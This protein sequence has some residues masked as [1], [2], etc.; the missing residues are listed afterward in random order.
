MSTAVTP[1]QAIE[2]NGTLA[3]PDAWDVHT[4]IVALRNLIVATFLQL[5]EALCRFKELRGWAK[6]GYPTFE[7]YLADPDVDISRSRAYKLMAVH[8]L[9]VEMFACASDTLLA[10]GYNKLGLLVPH[11]HSQNVDE[12][13][14]KAA[15][16]SRSDLR[17]ELRE[18][19][20]DDATPPLP[21]DY[22]TRYIW[23]KRI[24]RQKYWNHGRENKT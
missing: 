13:V 21:T 5:G 1:V 17:E 16:L 14:N 9:F 3:A 10:A 6:M 12:W 2:Q 15:A 23:C 7:S 22:R 18:A 24:L 11:V 20:G 19:F 4:D 8:E